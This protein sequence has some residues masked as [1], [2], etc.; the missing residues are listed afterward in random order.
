MREAL[1][2]KKM[3]DEDVKCDVCMH[4][5]LI[6][7]GK[8][9]ICGVRENHH[10]ILY[11]LNDGLTIAS[12]ID[13]IEKK[14]LY[15]F[16]E[17]T[18][19]YSFAAEGCNFKCPWCQN[20]EISQAP[21]H[22]GSV[23]GFKVSPLV[24][25]MEAIQNNCPAIAYTY[26]EPTVFLEYALDT[27]KI[28]KDKEL[29]NVWVTNGYMSKATLELITPYLDAANVDLK[30]GDDACYHQ[31]CGGSVIPVM[32]NMAYLLQHGVHLEITTLLVPGVNDSK[33]SIE[34]MVTLIVEYLGCSVPWHISRCFPHYKMKTI[35]PTAISTM[36]LAKS[37]GEAHGIQTIH[38][39]NI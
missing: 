27:M 13:P 19:I 16:L 3:A 2:Y 5:C 10:G 30:C 38:L 31:Y 11:A 23:N 21:K 15:H 39:G 26:S 7:S 29:M 32:E 12:A 18:K 20:H 37:I 17:H 34:K 1:L 6:E 35:K 8:R 36:N 28:A 25:V 9:G 22:E 4:G 33:E 24:H 14:P